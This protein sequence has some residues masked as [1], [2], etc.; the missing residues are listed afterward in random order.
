MI[1]ADLDEAHKTWLQ[2][3]QDERRR[4]EAAQSDCVAA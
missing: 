4:D 2:S 1:R 3:H